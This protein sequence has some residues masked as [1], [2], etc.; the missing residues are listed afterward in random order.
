MFR[1]ILRNVQFYLLLSSGLLA[2][3]AFQ[4]LNWYDQGIFPYAHTLID[5]PSY[6]SPD[7][8]TRGTLY[9]GDEA[10]AIGIFKFKVGLFKFALPTFS[11]EAEGWEREDHLR[12]PM[13]PTRKRKISVSRVGSKESVSKESLVVR[14]KFGDNFKQS[15]KASVAY[16]VLIP[17]HDQV[18]PSLRDRAAA[19]AASIRRAHMNS[20]YKHQLYAINLEHHSN[21]SKE[22]TNTCPRA[23]CEVMNELGYQIVDVTAS[24]LGSAASNGNKN[25]QKNLNS[26][27]NLSTTDP[28]SLNDLLSHHIVVHISLDSFLLQ[29][30]DSV[31]D[32]LLAEVNDDPSNILLQTKSTLPQTKTFNA[33]TKSKDATHF[34]SEECVN[35]HQPYVF[36]MSS[37]C[38]TIPYLELLKCLVSA[39]LE[40]SMT[41]DIHLERSE[42]MSVT[43]RPKKRSLLS[44]AVATD[45]IKENQFETNDHHCRIFNNNA[46]SDQ[47]IYAASSHQECSHVD[48]K[49]SAVIAS[50]SRSELDYTSQCAKPWEC[51]RNEN[52]QCFSSR[53]DGSAD[54]DCEWLQRE[55]FQLAKSL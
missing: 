7:E 17:R 12:V 13:P 26:Q 45:T 41:S 52:N 44:S 51:K 39:Q 32:D 50:F 21:S 19:L 6:G 27:N 4:H 20:P 37:R 46:L 3:L 35:A 31:F 11:N 55:W 16:A 9:Y 40:V 53:E 34:S 14:Q 33:N 29:S 49:K 42:I 15:S 38:G 8:S 2:L 30:M 1:G 18:T 23:C 36:K 22:M 25:K 54:A 10:K 43:V 24:S 28:Q 5:K 47:C 48:I